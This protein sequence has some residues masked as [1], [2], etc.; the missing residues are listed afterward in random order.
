MSAW[1]SNLLVHSE[2]KQVA[3]LLR[4]GEGLRHAHQK[5]A[6]T[7]LRRLSLQ[8]HS[9]VGALS[10]QARTLAAEAGHPIGQ[11]AQRKE[12]F[13]KPG[14]GLGV[15]YGCAVRVIVAVR[16]HEGRA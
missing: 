6:R 7:Q 11:A 10:Q 12:G 4:L 14:V 9:L 2:P 5:L 16:G 13:S 15:P 8:Q 1:A 3:R